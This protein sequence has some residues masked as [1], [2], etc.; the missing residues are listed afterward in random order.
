[1]GRILEKLILSI[2]F[3]EDMC[4]HLYYIISYLPIP[5]Q[6]HWCGNVWWKRNSRLLSFY[7]IEKY[8][9]FYNAFRKLFAVHLGKLAELSIDKS[10]LCLSEVSLKVKNEKGWIFYL[11]LTAAV[12]PEWALKKTTAF[13]FSRSSLLKW[14]WRLLRAFI[15]DNIKW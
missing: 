3:T 4:N 13:F 11:N 12:V 15:F 9:D 10:G 2:F 7:C 1:M 8:L 14:W 6:F 5:A